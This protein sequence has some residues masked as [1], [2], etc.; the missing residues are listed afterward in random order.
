MTSSKDNTR[1]KFST[2][3]WSRNGS[4]QIW[5]L[6]VLF[7]CSYIIYCYFNDLQFTPC[8]HPQPREKRSKRKHLAGCNHWYTFLFFF[9]SLKFY[10]VNKKVK[11][12]YIKTSVDLVTV[13]YDNNVSLSNGF[14]FIF[15]ISISV[16]KL[17]V[18]HVL[19]KYYTI[20]A[21]WLIYIFPL[22]L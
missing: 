19:G 15:A 11:N 9:I 14:P 13:V 16:W 3:V 5:I 6:N 18:Y 22:C 7:F 17:N 21:E 2:N 8:P 12:R 1:S 4:W 10:N 20:P